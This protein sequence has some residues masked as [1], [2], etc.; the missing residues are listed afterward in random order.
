MLACYSLEV[1]PLK[2]LYINITLWIIICLVQTIAYAKPFNVVVYTEEFPPLNYMH[3]T[4]GVSGHATQQIKTLLDAAGINYDIQL[5]SWY[6]AYQL[7]LTTPNT[8]IY[9]ILKTP[10]RESLFHWYCPIALPQN[11]NLFKL[12]TNQT[13]KVTQL[14]EAKA[15]ILGVMRGDYPSEFLISKGFEENKNLVYSSDEA[16]NTRML[17]SGRIDLIVQT[18]AALHFR[19]AELGLPKSKVTPVLK[20]IDGRPLSTC[21]A[22]NK[23]SDPALI[24]LL[25]ETFKTIKPKLKKDLQ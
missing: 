2:K 13:L 12:T 18:E 6:R 5:T 1:Y 24:H 25:D 21:L 4:D 19:L 3:S 11:I 15:Y 17:L 20:S 16:A 22:I 7:T 23:Q 14:N 10:E 9:T 8:L